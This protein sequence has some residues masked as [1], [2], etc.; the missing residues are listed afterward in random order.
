[1][2]SPF[3]FP[4]FIDNTMRASFVSCP[5]KFWWSFIHNLTPSRANTHLIAGGAFAKGLEIARKAFYV[6]GTSEEAATA[7]GLEA[8]LHAYGA[9]EPMTTGTEANK[10]AV[11]M[12]EAF[13]SYLSRYP[14]ETDTLRPAVFPSGPAIEFT[15]MLPLPSVRHPESGDPL[16]YCGRFDML[17]RRGEDYW[18]EDEKTTTSLGSQWMKTWELDSQMTGYCWASREY[19]VPVLGAIIRGIGILKTEINHVEVPVY[20]PEWII[21]RWLEQVERDANRMI[22]SW[23]TDTW[24]MALGHACSNYGGCP[25]AELCLSPTPDR[26]IEGRFEPR[27][28]D[29][30]A[31]KPEG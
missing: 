6:S 2:P 8:L 1:M 28:W 14:L 16:L 5:K 7:L 15:F 30:L 29:P 10:T 27:N 22:E 3:P 9:H 13:L 12:A 23:R 25:F 19:G 20:R 31:I 26:W 24:D 17:A 18:V 4:A 11:R 21:K